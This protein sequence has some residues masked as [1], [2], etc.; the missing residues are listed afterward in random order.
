MDLHAK[1]A[2]P[3]LSEKLQKKSAQS[4]HCPPQKAE[5][6]IVLIIENPKHEMRGTEK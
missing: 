5:P 3:F 4:E 1:I 2:H 6:A